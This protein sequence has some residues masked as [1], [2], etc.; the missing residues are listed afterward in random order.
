MGLTYQR[1]MSAS[2]YQRVSL[3]YAPESREF[4]W[5]FAFFFQDI[6]Q[7]EVVNVEFVSG[8]GAQPQFPA[9]LAIS[10]Q[11]WQFLPPLPK[12]RAR[13]DNICLTG[14]YLVPLEPRTLLTNS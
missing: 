9:I 4:H 3:Q 13:R 7:C 11:F 2:R 8:C 1:R 6:L 12:T 14:T 10:W 5:G